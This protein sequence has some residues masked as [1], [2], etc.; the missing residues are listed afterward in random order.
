MPFCSRKCVYCDFASVANDKLISA[1]FEAIKRES[2]LILEMTGPIEIFTIYFGGGTPSH[3]PI[4][5]IEDLMTKIT[6]IF[7]VSVEEITFEMNPE[8][9]TREKCLRLK[10]IGVN[11][12]SLG[13]QSTSND[14]LKVIGRPY[15]FETFLKRY[16]IIRE[17]FDN[18]NLDLMYNLPFE[19]ISDVESDLRVI[20]RLKPDHISFYE[21]ELHEEV[22]LYSMVNANIVKLPSEEI[23][24]KMYDMI[25]E[26]LS[27][28]GYQ[29]YE[30]SSWT[31]EKPSIHN[32]NYWQNGQ[33]IGMGLSAGSH[34]G[35][36]RWTN[37]SNIND[38]ISK[39]KMNFLPW[40][41]YNENSPTDEIAE[42]LFMGLRLARG[43]SKKMLE[44]KFGESLTNVYLKKLEKFNGTFLENKDDFVKFTKDG[45]KFSALVLSELV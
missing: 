5:N 10:G 23:S 32:I 28:L 39:I 26:G 36:K 38:Y 31:F 22:P 19:R 14:I 15:T 8:D 11:R 3:V 6:S 18:V 37:F 4:D 42:T 29:R 9:V 16:S 27:N 13:L 35:T 40:E 7:K 30:L 45:M 33:Y 25:I 41:Y 44:A 43:I 21:L 20:E 17:Y 12:I 1:Y 2:D 24:E 34:F